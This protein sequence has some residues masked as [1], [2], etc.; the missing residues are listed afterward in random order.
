MILK[1]KK[2]VQ[3]LKD[4]LSLVTGEQRTDLLTDEEIERFVRR[5]YLCSVSPVSLSVTDIYLV[6]LK[7]TSPDFLHRA[8]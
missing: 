1:L 2:E 7:Q 5:C 8:R 4:E 6:N 3:S